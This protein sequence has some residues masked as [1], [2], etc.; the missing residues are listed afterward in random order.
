MMLL[1]LE[2][3]RR[4][5]EGRSGREVMGQR[6]TVTNNEQGQYNACGHSD[7]IMWFS[8]LLSKQL[9]FES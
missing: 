6:V 8:R 1:F 2:P 7:E 3:C 5:R 9:D 4:E